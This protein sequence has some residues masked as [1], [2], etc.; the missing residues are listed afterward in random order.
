MLNLESIFICHD[1]QKMCGST[2]ECNNCYLTMDL[3][4]Y[5]AGTYFSAIDVDFAEG[6][7]SFWDEDDTDA[8]VMTC[9]FKIVI[10]T[11]RDTRGR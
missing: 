10:T 6:I 3:R 8:S 5:K 2:L 7:I 11:A 1:K 9:D 4:G